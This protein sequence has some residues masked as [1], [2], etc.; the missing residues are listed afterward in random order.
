MEQYEIRMVFKAENESLVRELMK[1]IA[2]FVKEKKEPGSE[3]VQ[4]EYVLW[5]FQK[6]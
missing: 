5:E 6:K 3:F 2:K 4:V 1:E